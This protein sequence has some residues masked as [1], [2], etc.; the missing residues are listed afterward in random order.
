MAEIY[1]R[2]DMQYGTYL[3]WREGYVGFDLEDA[4]QIFEGQ[5]YSVDVYC[6]NHSVTTIVTDSEIWT[7]SE[8]NWDVKVDPGVPGYDQLNGGDGDDVLDLGLG[9]GFG[10]GGAGNDTLTG[11]STGTSLNLKVAWATT[12]SPPPAPA[13]LSWVATT[14]TTPSPAAA[15]LITCKV[16]WEQIS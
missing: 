16:G 3:D 13:P 11:D 1:V 5:T 10:Q 9:G 2:A 7:V 14:A 6:R 12:P 8:Y 4:V 15:A